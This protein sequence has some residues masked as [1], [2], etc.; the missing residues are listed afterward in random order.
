MRRPAPND[1]GVSLGGSLNYQLPQAFREAGAAGVGWVRMTVAWSW[2]EPKP[3]VF[4]FHDFDL[5]VG[6]ARAAGLDV[7][8]TL[9]L[10]VPWDA[11]APASVTGDARIDYPPA[12]IAAWE[13]YVYR[14]VT[15]FKR[16]IH[17]WE[18]WNEPDLQGFWHGTAAQYAQLLAVSY[19]EVKR[20]DAGAHVLLGGLSLA[21]TP[22]RYDP[23]FLQEILG[24]PRYPAAR[25][26]DIA[27]FHQ[28]G[29][30][31]QASQR[32]SYV[33]G[34]LTRHG[35]GG[36]PVWVT[37]VGYSSDPGQ[38]QIPGY[39]TGDPQANQ[40]RYLDDMLPFLLD[41]LGV[42]KV[43]WFSLQDVPAADPTFSHHG[44]VTAD[45]VPKAAL[46]QVAVIE[47]R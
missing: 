26:F 27:N 39:D 31:A 35:A 47:R 1:I 15:H 37:E 33:T 18:I 2:I 21:G 45:D 19:Q 29:S 40:A 23:N 22:G 3:G 41:T 12:D 13:Q 20:A 7:L 4:D 5:A 14:T 34:E 43:F 8:G 17:V 44:L 42:A 36:K 32:M 25:Y 46:A 28:Y 24:N 10:G 16:D 6:S 9:G 38:Q 11:T 30:A